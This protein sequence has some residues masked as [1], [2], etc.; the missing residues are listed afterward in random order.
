MA[1]KD[2]DVIYIGT[3]VRVTAD[4]VLLDSDTGHLK[5][6]Q[7]TTVVAAFRDWS[8]YF[9]SQNAKEPQ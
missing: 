3:R 7:G 4:E 5:F 6:K 8:A 2:Y 1:T 9:E